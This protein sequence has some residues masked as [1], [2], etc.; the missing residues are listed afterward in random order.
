MKNSWIIKADTET[1]KEIIN[2]M[3]E[4]GCDLQIKVLENDLNI[5]IETDEQGDE[6]MKNL[7][8]G[9]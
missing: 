5:R 4:L 1:A 6:Y 3:I 9:V 8:E 2:D 7:L